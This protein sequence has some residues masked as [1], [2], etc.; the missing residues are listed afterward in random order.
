M[1]SKSQ[2]VREYFIKHP[3]AT[4]KEVG[5]KFKCAMPVV[6]KIRKEAM[7]EVQELNAHAIVNPQITDAV[8]QFTP[9]KQANRKQIGGDHY[10]NMGVQ[11]WKAMESW[12]TPEEFRGFL[13]GNAIKYLARSNTKGGA[14]DVQKAGHYIEKLVEVMGDA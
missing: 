7:A 9:S 14:T 3:L 6:Y 13:K 10:M 11:P 2:K 1:K 8:T 12:M 4:P 5:V